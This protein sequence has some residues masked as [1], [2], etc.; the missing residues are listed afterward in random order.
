MWIQSI[1][2][3]NYMN[4]NRVL[5]IIAAGNGS[6]MGY[7]PK[8]ISLVKGTPNL[9]NT[10]DKAYEQFDKIFIFTLEKYKGLFEEVVES[11]SDKCKV[12]DIISGYGCGDAVR[13]SML[14]VKN[15]LG[16]SFVMMWGDVYVSDGK[17]F[18]EILLNP[19]PSPLL[20]PTI[21]ENDPYVWFPKYEDR[22]VR[23]AMFKKRDETIEEGYHDQS[24]F[25]LK[26]DEMF[27]VLNM[28]Y[29]V[30]RK[31][32]NYL[33][34]ELVF[35]DSVHVLFN[36]GKP[37]EIYVTNYETMGYNTHGELKNINKKLKG[38]KD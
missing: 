6:R 30:N 7:L 5:M 9:Y 19:S 38:K 26:K 27:E 37:A 16:T 20:I 8:A 13:T 36:I 3:D 23:A 17:I 4:E 11:F 2:K 18:E 28:M 35:L 31:M 33:H 34:N 21:L 15:E 25:R 29:V 1:L 24:I 32:N 12:I 22:R 14:S 10:V